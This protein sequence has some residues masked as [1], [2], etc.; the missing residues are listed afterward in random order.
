MSVYQ[1]PIPGVPRVNITCGGIN[2]STKVDGTIE[3]VNATDSA[4]PAH[5]L[6]N[7]PAD[8]RYAGNVTISAEKKNINFTFRSGA[9]GAKV[10]CEIIGTGAESDYRMNADAWEPT[11][12]RTAAAFRLCRYLGIPWAPQTRTVEVWLNGVYWGTYTLIEKIEKHVNRVN[13]GSGSSWFAELVVDIQED[14]ADPLFKTRYLTANPNPI[15]AHAVERS[16]LIEEGTGANAQATMAIFEDALD[17]NNWTAVAGVIDVEAVAS[18][19]VASE[20]IRNSDQASHGMRLIYDTSANSGSR[21]RLWFIP[22][23]FDVSFGNLGGAVEGYGMN[24]QDWYAKL[25]TFPQFNAAV[26]DVWA[27]KLHVIRHWQAE[28][29]RIGNYLIT[30]GAGVRN[31]DKWGTVMPPFGGESAIATSSYEAAVADLH[32][33]IES[34]IA[35]LNAQFSAAPLVIPRPYALTAAS[36]LP[37]LLLHMEHDDVI[38][39]LDTQTESIPVRFGNPPLR[40]SATLP[41]VRK[42]RGM[43]IPGEAQARFPLLSN[44]VSELNVFVMWAGPMQAWTANNMMYFIKTISG[45]DKIIRIYNH[46]VGSATMTK[47]VMDAHSLPVS[48]T[49]IERHQFLFGRPTLYRL[50]FKIVAGA[51]VATMT[52]MASGKFITNSFA[53]MT[54]L[55]NRIEFTTGGQ[56][57]QYVLALIAMDSALTA[58]QV[59]GVASY[60][61]GRFGYTA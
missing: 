5:Q 4:F 27:T 15:H 22:W 49:G 50:N 33:Y 26:R 32:A 44:P 60:L 20:I 35:W 3:F 52:D 8:F 7:G 6:Y 51:C 40:V 55:P 47:W 57:P 9:A 14:P 10:V 42:A 61:Q 38:A 13:L 11:Q 46:T 2:P 48:V 36:Y 31:H 41:W 58:S 43:M 21:S 59:N 23:D 37:G 28:C 25:L 56:P 54:E 19:Y 53:H 30:S 34:R 29:R 39:A 12:M 18:F 24:V 45:A 16:L 17:A 1:L